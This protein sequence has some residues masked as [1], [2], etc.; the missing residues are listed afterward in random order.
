MSEGVK[1]YHLSPVTHQKFK[2]L[3]SI[4]GIKPGF[5]MVTQTP[6]GWAGNNSPLHDALQQL[7]LDVK[8]EKV[9]LRDDLKGSSLLPKP[10]WQDQNIRAGSWGCNHRCVCPAGLGPCFAFLVGLLER[11]GGIITLS[12]PQPGG[13]EVNKSRLC[14]VLWGSPQNIAL[15]WCSKSPALAWLMALHHFSIHSL[16]LQ[17]KPIWIHLTLQIKLL[18]DAVSDVLLQSIYSGTV[19]PFPKAVN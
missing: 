10:W 16:M 1:I 15:T 3:N 17:W 11:A 2:K 6:W 12:V 14:T 4:K 13:M 7:F 8:A 5:P 18:W 19:F 9:V